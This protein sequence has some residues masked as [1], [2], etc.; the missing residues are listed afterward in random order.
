MHAR[1]TYTLPPYTNSQ[2]THRPIKTTVILEDRVWY[3]GTISTRCVSYYQYITWTALR[4]TQAMV[5]VSGHQRRCH[6]YK[7]SNDK[8]R[9]NNT[10]HHITCYYWIHNDKELSRCPHGSAM[11]VLLGKSYYI[12][13]FTKCNYSKLYVWP[14]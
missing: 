4:C 9:L 7:V 3:N 6:E 1:T 14:S 8:C 5:I 2:A 10:S 13:I 12:H 11:F